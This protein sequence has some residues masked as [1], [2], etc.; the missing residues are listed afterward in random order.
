MQRSFAQKYIA[1]E[2]VFNFIKSSSLDVPLNSKYAVE[3]SHPYKTFPQI[4]EQDMMMK[5]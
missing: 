5:N 4:S 1:C 3:F 2:T